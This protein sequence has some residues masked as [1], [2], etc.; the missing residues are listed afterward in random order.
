MDQAE[1]EALLDDVSDKDGDDDSLGL[2]EEDE[3]DVLVA[4]KESPD[5]RMGATD[6]RMARRRNGAIRVG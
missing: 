3:L 6:R 5:V 1:P 2:E 4:L